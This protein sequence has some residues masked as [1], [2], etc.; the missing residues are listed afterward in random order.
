MDVVCNIDDNYT[1]FCGVMLTS[2]FE[3]N[4]DEDITVHV[5]GR[6]LASGTREVL[7]DL[8]ERK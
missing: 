1:K 4:R 8:V 7:T 2:L 3:N 6:A 5:L